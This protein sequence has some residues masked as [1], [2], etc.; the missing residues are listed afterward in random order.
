MQN[1]PALGADPST[2]GTRFAPPRNMEISIPERSGEEPRGIETHLEAAIASARE[3][4]VEAQRIDNHAI[5]QAFLS[6]LTH[7]ARAQAF[8]GSSASL[9]LK[10]PHALPHEQV[11]TATFAVGDGANDAEVV[12]E[13]ARGKPG[14]WPS[15]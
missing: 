12:P 14:N 15:F 6:C 7:L 13:D 10:E 8:A 5:Q 9:E 2:P 3:G 4:L 1:A 11:S